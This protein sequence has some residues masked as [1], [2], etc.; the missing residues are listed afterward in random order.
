MFLAK[1]LLRFNDFLLIVISVDK[2][3]FDVALGV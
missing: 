1:K 3:E 2:E